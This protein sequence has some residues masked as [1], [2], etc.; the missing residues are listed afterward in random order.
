VNSDANT[1][2]NRATGEHITFLENSPARL[3]FENRIDSGQQPPPLHIHP[4]QDERFTLLEGAF[5]L[6]LDGRSQPLQPGQSVLV[7]KDTAHTFRIPLGSSA[8]LRIEFEP[9]LDTEVVFRTLAHAG[10]SGRINPLYVALIARHTRAGFVI[11][12]IP[13]AVQNLLWTVFAFIAR[14]LGL[15]LETASGA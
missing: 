9:A 3:V 12:G 5:E 6:V 13:R 14:G 10:R 2:R 8:R 7:R 4:H 1:I 15:R 11:G